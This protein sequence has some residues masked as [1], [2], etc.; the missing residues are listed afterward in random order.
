MDEKYKFDFL[1]FH[2]SQ[3]IGKDGAARSF[4]SENT[5]VYV[6]NLLK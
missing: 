4:T 2:L 3:V 1:E 6:P 5:Q